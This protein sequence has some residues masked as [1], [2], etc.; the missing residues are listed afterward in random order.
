MPQRSQSHVNEG[1]TMKR[2]LA[3]INRAPAPGKNGGFVLLLFMIVTIGV[4]GVLLVSRLNAGAAQVA[5]DQAT[6]ETLRIASDALI[7]Y[8]AGRRFSAGV[9]MPG[10]LPCPDLNDD[11]DAEGSCGSASGNTQQ[12]NRLGRLPWRTLGIPDLRDGSGERLW[13]AVSSKYKA[14]T[15]NLDLNPTT[16]RGTITLRDSAGTVI[17]DGTS[18]D[19]Y[20]GSSGGAVALII[21]PG[22]VLKRQGAAA[23]QDRSCSGGSCNPA[24]DPAGTCT[25]TPTSL[26]AKCNP[27]NYLDTALGEDNAN[28][29]DDNV[30]RTANG[31]GFIKGPVLVS[32]EIA[33][34]DRIIAIT[35]DQIMSA[36]QQRI[37]SEAMGCL[38]LY[39]A[40]NR[41]RYPWPAPVCRQANLM[42]VNA[43]SD[44]DSVSFGRIP[45]TNF[46]TTIAYS[47]ADTW[48]AGECN[49]GFAWWS[50]WKMHVFYAVADAYKPN[51][52]GNGGPCTTSSSCL[53][54][55]DSGGNVI[56]AS[57]QIAVIVAGRPLNTTTPAQVRGGSNDGYASNYLEISNKALEG[58]IN[59]PLPAACSSLTPAPV[60]TACSP[61]SSCNK[62]TSS[63]RQ[64]GLNDVVIYYP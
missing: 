31:N 60:S 13:Y 4:I 9:P 42:D 19:I 53:Q 15:A 11:G 41:G 62:V 49:I 50:A 64:S 22:Q 36:V 30:T 14:A 23:Q 24:G 20:A 21:A 37:A 1:L 34:N 7:A 32:G 27:A 54:V 25:S 33:V 46:D 12:Q 28:F 38:R 29:V 3:K 17:H 6:D 47:M 48:G 63:V 5:R 2:A 16:G 58:L 40:A 57:K 56:A 61:L 55:Q 26:T 10:S 59:A 18:S 45:D 43:W 44:H 52:T 51:A 39:A 8:A 35:Q